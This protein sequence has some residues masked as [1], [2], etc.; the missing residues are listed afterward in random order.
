MHADLLYYYEGKALALSGDYRA[1]LAALEEA[2]RRNPQ[3]PAVQIAIGGLHGQI[4]QFYQPAA[5]PQPHQRWSQARE[6]FQQ[7][8]D[9]RPNDPW[10]HERLACVLMNQ[11]EYDGA[12][13]EYQAAIRLMYG[14]RLAYGDYCNLGVAQQ[15]SQLL[16]E[17]RTS[18]GRCL[19]LAPAAGGQAHAR[20]LLAAL[21]AAAVPQAR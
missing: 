20:E 8:V 11:Q 19:A 12:I 3:D 5:D 13:L 1:G 4:G 10:A 16:A 15:H 21:P 9:L 14:E 7:A 17:A 6:H 2:A 18:Y